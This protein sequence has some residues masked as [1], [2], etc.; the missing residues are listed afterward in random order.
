MKIRRV[1]GDA[2]LGAVHRCGA[3]S[4]PTDAL[5]DY[6]AFEAAVRQI[7]V[8]EEAWYRTHQVALATVAFLF[9]FCVAAALY[10]ALF[11]AASAEDVAAFAD[12]ASNG[13]LPTGRQPVTFLY[14]AAPTS[15]APICL[16]LVFL[17]HTVRC[18]ACVQSPDAF[19]AS[20]NA[21][22]ERTLGLHYDR[23]SRRL[24]RLTPPA[25]AATTPAAGSDS[26]D[27]EIRSEVSSPL[28]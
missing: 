13:S 24:Q 28:D 23:Y 12:G 7:V 22:L 5:R 4:S 26:C 15:A 18:H 10:N 6:A 9:A 3:L 27:D 19:V 21:T 2:S 17:L 16:V 8:R 25:A 14:I 1:D 20:L 11:A